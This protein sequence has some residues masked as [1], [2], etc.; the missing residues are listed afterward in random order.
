[1]SGGK[2]ASFTNCNISGFISTC[3]IPSRIMENGVAA[4]FCRKPAKQQM[5]LECQFAFTSLY[6]GF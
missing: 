6:V 3:I 1:M 2:S 4:L 5:L